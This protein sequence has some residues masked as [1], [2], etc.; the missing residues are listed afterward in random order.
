MKHYSTI[1]HII[2]I[3]KKIC[4]ILKNVLFYRKMQDK[5][6]SNG[7]GQIYFRSKGTW[8]GYSVHSPMKP[9]IFARQNYGIT[10]IERNIV[11]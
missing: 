9:E 6:G 5:I 10:K 4:E 8:E 1:G 7:S 11:L 2:P 3:R